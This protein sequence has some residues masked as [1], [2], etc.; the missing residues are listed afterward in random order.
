MGNHTLN[1]G[2]VCISSSFWLRKNKLGIKN[3]QTLVL[4]RAHI[5]ITDRHNHETL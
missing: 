5:E 4:H 3:I 1:I 2:E